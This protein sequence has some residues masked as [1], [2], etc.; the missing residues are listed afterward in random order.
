[1]KHKTLSEGNTSTAL[2]HLSDIGILA[3]TLYLAMQVLFEGA[4]KSVLQTSESQH[5]S[6]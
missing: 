6:L 5:V 2:P 1:M 3:Y 4:R